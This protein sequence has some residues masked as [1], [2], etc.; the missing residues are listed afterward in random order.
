MYDITKA[1]LITEYSN[2][3]DRGNFNYV[4]EDLYVTKGGHY[5]YTLKEDRNRS[6]ANQMVTLRGG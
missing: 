2:G 4:Y 3:L 5:F 6:I 1:N